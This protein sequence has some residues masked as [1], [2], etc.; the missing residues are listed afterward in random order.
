MAVPCAWLIKCRRCLNTRIKEITIFLLLLCSYPWCFPCFCFQGAEDAAVHV[1]LVSGYQSTKVTNFFQYDP[2][3]NP[4]VVS[5]SRN[6]SSIAGEKCL[7]ASRCVWDIICRTAVIADGGG[8]EGI[9][10]HGV[11]WCY[12][13]FCCFL[14]SCSPRAPCRFWSHLVSFF[15]FSPSYIRKWVACLSPVWIMSTECQVEYVV[16][17]EFILL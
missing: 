10:V 8:T 9:E 6:R 2:S 3:L 4:T 14:L 16:P 7:S 1:T 12:A 11:W 17:L 13:V 5:L 15:F